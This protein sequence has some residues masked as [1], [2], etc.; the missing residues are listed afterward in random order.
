VDA[1]TEDDINGT[2]VAI[3]FATVML[4]VDVV[5]TEIKFIKIKEF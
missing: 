5:V 2:F 1:T 3:A 4:F